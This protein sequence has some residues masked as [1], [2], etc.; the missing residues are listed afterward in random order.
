M[1]NKKSK[2]YILYDGYKGYEEIYTVASLTSTTL[3][4]EEKGTDEDGP[5]YYKETY[6]R[7][8]ISED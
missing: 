6:R 4:L 2:L 7:A 3:I 5:Y 8:N 1:G